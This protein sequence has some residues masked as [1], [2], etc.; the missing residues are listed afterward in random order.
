MK[1]LVWMKVFKVLIFAMFFPMHVNMLLLIKKIARISSLCNQD[2]LVKFA[3]MYT[4]YG[5]MESVD[6]NETRF[7]HIQNSLQE[8]KH[9]SVGKVII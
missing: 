7:V 1:S 2:C 8:I 6:K 3:K 5:N 9:F 4:R